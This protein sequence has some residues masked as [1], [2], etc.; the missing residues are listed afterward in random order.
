MSS[1]VPLTF[2]AGTATLASKPAVASKL[3]GVG[4]AIV[5]PFSGTNGVDLDIESLNRLIDSQISGGLDFIV[6]MGTTG[7]CPT[8][9]HAEHELVIKTTVERVAGRIPV[10][11][12]AGSNSTAEA[13]SLTAFAKKCGADAVLLVN[14]Y[15]NKPNQ[16]G[17]YMHFK[18]IAEATDMPI[19][20]YNIPSRCGITMQ[21][22]T[23][24]RLWNDCSQIVAIKEAT[25]SLDIASKIRELCPIPI[26]SGDDTLTLPLMSIGGC[27]VVSV[28]SN[29]A[30]ELVKSIVDNAASGNWAEAGANHIRLHRLMR[31]M[32]IDTNPV[33]VKVAAAEMGIISSAEVRLPMA[34][35][36]E[37]SRKILM[38]C[39]KDYGLV[40]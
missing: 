23:V 15:Y 37:G 10:V 32:F 27:G 7:E 22:E 1:F 17:L 12:G 19:V 40:E 18:A 6:P 20:L 14:P 2:P 31:T 38:S 9:S 3:S 28:L 11:A 30:P 29:I 4:T 13:I 34:P 16:E 25:G 24:A 39:L 33:P 5:T 26:L 35:I 21:P 8:V 36:N